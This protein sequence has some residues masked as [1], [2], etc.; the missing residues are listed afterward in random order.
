MRFTSIPNRGLVK[1]A[2]DD[3]FS[4]LQNIVTN[5]LSLLDRQK[6][7]YAC[8]LTPQGKFIHDFFIT[9]HSDEFWL[10]CE[11]G[12]RTEDLHKKLLLY[13]LRSKVT[14]EALP[15]ID[16]YATTEPTDYPDP[17]LKEL[18]YRSYTKPQGTEMPFEEYDEQ[19][20]KL[21]VPDGS[22]DTELGVS[23][24]EELNIPQLNGVS[25]EKGCYIGQELTA[26]MHHRGLA[27]KHL[28]PFAKDSI[29]EGAE[30]R[31]SAGNYVL[32]LVKDK[33]MQ[34]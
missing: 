27:K 6:M 22:R 19:R 16:V 21:G 4:F 28:R 14:L 26:R 20:I 1:V 2:G 31:S 24:L 33:D 9:R 17:R 7:L 10:E 18:G 32:A 5:D 34:V 29:P 25:Y 30:T 3:A 11:G 8:L 23:T 12:S 15:H 13:K